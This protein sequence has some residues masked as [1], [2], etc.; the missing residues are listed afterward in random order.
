[1][2]KIV[3]IGLLMIFIIVSTPTLHAM[4][5]LNQIGIS[6][7]IDEWDTIEDEEPLD[8]YFDILIP[9]VQFSYVIRPSIVTDNFKA[10]FPDYEHYDYLY[11]DTWISYLA[12]FEDANYYETHEPYTFEF[13]SH[14]NELN[15][16]TSFKV[17]KINS[18][19]DITSESEVIVFPA[20]NQFEKQDIILNYDIQNDSFEIVQL[21]SER[22]IFFAFMILFGIS[23][24]FL[25]FIVRFLVINGLK[26]KNNIEKKILFVQLLTT[27]PASLFM[28]QLLFNYPIF[29]ESYYLYVLFF[30][31]LFVETLILYFT[32]KDKSLYGQAI[33]FN[34]IS[35]LPYAALSLLLYLL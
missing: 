22:I 21:V 16:A 33:K 20:L 23:F 7:T 27:V 3:I 14:F 29:Q 34:T 17:V 13:Y 30:G 6:V 12:Y 10:Q 15:F 24:T 4:S 2:K 25:H 26:V 19:G 5:Y 1:M 9:I 31:I 11:S 8:G 28:V 18:E 32:V 35:Y